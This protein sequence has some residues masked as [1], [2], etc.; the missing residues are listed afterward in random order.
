MS[1]V[2]DADAARPPQV[3]QPLLSDARATFKPKAPGVFPPSLLTVLVVVEE[4]EPALAPGLERILGRRAQG[5]ARRERGVVL[6]L[7][8][9]AAGDAGARDVGP[10]FAGADEPSRDAEA[11][12]L[13]RRLAQERLALGLLVG[14]DEVRRKKGAEVEAKRAAEAGAAKA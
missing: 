4:P 1:P 8:A 3:F 12:E 5:R 2:P 6:A 9:A 10:A 13:W 14:M 11:A 7:G